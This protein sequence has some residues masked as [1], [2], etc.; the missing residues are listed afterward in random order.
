MPF[1]SEKQRRYLWAN[2]PEIAR[3]WAD[4]YGSRIESNRG[5]ITRT[6]FGTGLTKEYQDFEN[7][8]NARNKFQREQTIEELKKD[9]Y[10]DKELQKTQNQ[11][12][13]VATGGI[14]RLGY[15]DGPAGGASAGGDYGGNVN[16]QQEYAGRTFAE[17][18]GGGNNTGG[19]GNIG[20]NEPA[21]NPVGPNYPG[22]GPMFNTALVNK[23]IA[24]DKLISWH[25]NQEA[26]KAEEADDEEIKSPTSG[27]EA[28]DVSGRAQKNKLKK[29]AA[30]AA[31]YK[32]ANWKYAQG[33]RIGYADGPITDDYGNTYE[34][35]H[36]SYS[37]YSLD[38]FKE[39][40]GGMDYQVTEEKEETG[41]NPLEK[42]LSLSPVK[43]AMGMFKGPDLT[44]QQ[45]DM[46]QAYMT[47]YNVGRNPITGRMVGGPFSGM[48]APGTSAFG[49]KDV[50]QMATK[51]LNK[52]GHT[53]PIEKVHQMSA[54]AGKD[55]GNPAQMGTS[56]P[57]TATSYSSAGKTGAKEGYSY[58][59]NRG[60]VA[61]LWRR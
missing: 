36:A 26:Q 58:G 18:Y 4:T 39:K 46:N 32:E 21:V 52:F 54:L 20:A 11:K 27:Y 24:L 35:R 30:M 12:S 13:M 56:H 50:D 43:A 22:V 6:A 48:N 57:S 38:Q 23:Q 60:G 16:P 40:F 15:A 1:Q 44:Q 10:R 29:D 51:W 33:G 41:G 34:N 61:G 3:D 55:T 5:G 49:S 19:N 8:F 9:Y 47:N 42:L 45:R 59:L 14:M 28:L 17:T 37:D 7:W 25:D 2:E 53:A 31:L